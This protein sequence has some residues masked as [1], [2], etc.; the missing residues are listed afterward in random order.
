MCHIIIKFQHV[1][2]TSQKSPDVLFNYSY[3][4]TE[5]MACRLQTYSTVLILHISPVQQCIIIWSFTKLCSK[6]GHLLLHDFH[7]VIKVTLQFI[8]APLIPSA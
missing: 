1:T 2:G 4:A 8:N 5:R 7:Y 6:Y 3:C